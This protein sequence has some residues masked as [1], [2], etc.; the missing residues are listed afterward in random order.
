MDDA[1]R[2]DAI[3]RLHRESLLRFFVHRTGDRALSEDLCSIVFYEAWRRRADVDLVAR[4]PLPWLYGAAA[5][6][7]RNQRRSG[8]SSTSAW[9]AT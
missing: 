5:N 1:E 2:F 7:L 9:P 3:F 4:E 6:V 8:P